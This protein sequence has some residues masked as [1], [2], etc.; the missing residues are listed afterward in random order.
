M[1][2]K[3]NRRLFVLFLSLFVIYLIYIIVFGIADRSFIDFTNFKQSSVETYRDWNDYKFLAYEDIRTGL[4]ERGQPVILTDPEEIELNQKSIERTGFSVLVSD[5]ISVNRTIPK[6]VH[7]DCLYKKYFA[8]LPKTSVII[9]FY[10]E[11]LSV[12]LRT[13]HS[14]YNRTPKELLHEIILVN[15]D[16]TEEE[17]GGKLKDYLDENFPRNLVS[18][19]Q[20]LQLNVV[21][22]ECH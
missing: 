14:V 4:G 18:N 7:P 2:I 13:V 21:N 1:Q 22:A 6:F 16:S 15:D 12:L 8:D 19:L 20:K 17:L 10:N 11:V 9:I 5:K 3:I